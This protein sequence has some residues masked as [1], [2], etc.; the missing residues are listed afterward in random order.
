MPTEPNLMYNHPKQQLLGSLLQLLHV[1]L[2]Q[3]LGGQLGL[4]EDQEVVWDDPT[5]F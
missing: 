4:A 1:D 2:G 3:G 5:V